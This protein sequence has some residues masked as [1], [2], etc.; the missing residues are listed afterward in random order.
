MATIPLELPSVDLYY[1]FTKKTVF[2]ISCERTLASV[3]VEEDS[4]YLPSL[5]PKDSEGKVSS[6]PLQVTSIALAGYENLVSIDGCSKD[7][8]LYVGSTSGAVFQVDKSSGQTVSQ[9]AVENRKDD[10]VVLRAWENMLVVGYD[11]GRVR[12]WDNRQAKKP[13]F[14]YRGHAD[15]V[16]DIIVREPTDTLDLTTVLSSGGDGTISIFE[17]RS[18]SMPTVTESIY[19]EI[20]CLS[21]IKGGSILVGGTLEGDLIMFEWRLWD[22]LLDNCKGHPDAIGDICNIDNDTLL[23]G[24]DDGLLRLVNIHPNQMIGVVGVPF[25]LPIEKLIL[26]PVFKTLICSS[27]ESFVRCFDVSCLYEKDGSIDMQK[28]IDTSVEGKKRK[29]TF[30]HETVSSFF[31]DL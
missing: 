12:L 8:T 10:A 1:D 2:Y 13:A 27:Y 16:T 25:E 7:D 19:D 4:F 3:H 9:W 29:T 15:S 31:D 18:S 23:T 24:S 6:D 14:S 30:G 21:L 5:I 22:K 17:L 11:S 28:T 20:T 26:E